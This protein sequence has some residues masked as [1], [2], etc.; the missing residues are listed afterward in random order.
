M[1][2]ILLFATLLFGS[3]L[4]Q[5][6]VQGK[7]VTYTADGTILKGY[8]AYD[9]AIKGRR[10]GILVV[11]EWWGHNDYAR[12]RA[13]MLAEMGYVA[14]ALDMYGDGKQAHHPD[15]AARFS[16]ELAKNLPLAKVRFESAMKLLRHQKNVDAE[17]IAALGYCFGGSMAL[18]MARLGEDLKGV[19]SFHGGLATEMPAQ[20]GKVK[21]QIISFTGTDDPM[22]P[23]E[24]VVAFKQEMDRA[25]VNY[26][27]VTF[28]GVK[29]SFTDP[30]ADEYGRKFNLPLAYDAAA[31]KASWDETKSF[32]ADVFGSK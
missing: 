13:M 28:I 30:A 11:H 6:T 15:E 31:D 3:S 16:A 1:K 27:A 19:A 9:D 18:Q 17:N 20:P 10:P 14:L 7:E 21:A 5:A 25:G 32:L 24:Q 2:N 23:A 12:K 8:I 22:I 4:V 26:K 29:H